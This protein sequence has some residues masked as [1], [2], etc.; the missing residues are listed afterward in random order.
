MITKACGDESMF[1][2]MD[3]AHLECQG[4]G[5]EAAD[6][7]VENVNVCRQCNDILMDGTDLLEENRRLKGIIDSLN[8]D[9]ADIRETFERLAVLVE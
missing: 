2:Y 5:V 8:S 6:A 4:C 3:R 1:D 9:I 7:D